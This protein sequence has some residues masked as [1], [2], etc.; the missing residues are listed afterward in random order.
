MESIFGI[1]DCIKIQS[2]TLFIYSWHIFFFVYGYLTMYQSYL[3]TLFS[4]DSLESRERGRSSLV[5]FC[6]EYNQF[7]SVFVTE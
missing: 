1:V 6:T 4:I 2:F 3:T 5:V 7:G